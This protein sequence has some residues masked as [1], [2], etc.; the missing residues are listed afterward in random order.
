MIFNG[1]AFSIGGN[2]FFFVKCQNVELNKNKVCEIVFS[3]FVSV[4]ILQKNS[5][6]SDCEN[7][8]DCLLSTKNEMKA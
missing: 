2:Y 8:S 7:S 6:F 1:S 4:V 3:R 5:S